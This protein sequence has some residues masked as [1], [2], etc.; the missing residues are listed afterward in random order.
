MFVRSR[1][2]AVVFS[3]CAQLCLAGAWT[4][5]S[6]PVQITLCLALKDVLAIVHRLLQK[7]IMET[8]TETGV[9]HFRGSVVSFTDLTN[10]KPITK[11]SLSV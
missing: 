8:Q 9:S 3:L 11:A 1:A 5:S 7:D 6:C 10:P 4:R 2:K